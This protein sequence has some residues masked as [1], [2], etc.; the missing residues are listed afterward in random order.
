MWFKLLFSPQMRRIGLFLRA[1]YKNELCI[2]HTIVAACVP[3][4]S[5]KK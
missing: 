4:I 3:A 2:D 5:I 1:Y